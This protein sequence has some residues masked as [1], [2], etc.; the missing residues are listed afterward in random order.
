VRPA[1]RRRRH[2]RRRHGRRLVT[3]EATRRRYS[4]TQPTTPYTPVDGARC[5]RAST[6]IRTRRSSPR[7]TDAAR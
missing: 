6:P 3:D 5:K 1:A 7:R 2:D 4:T